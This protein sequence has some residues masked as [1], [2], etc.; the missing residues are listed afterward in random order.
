[1]RD[2]LRKY[3]KD[4]ISNSPRRAAAVLAVGIAMA[5]AAIFVRQRT[6]AAERANPP[7]GQFIEV[8]GV[9]LHYV[10]RGQGQ[11]LVLLHGNG[12]MVQDFDISGLIDL[13][14]EHYCVIAFDRPGFGYSERPRTRIW[15]PEAQADLLHKALQRLGVSNAVVL[16]HSWG[17]LV[18]L[19]LALK[20]SSDVQ[21]LVLLSGYYFP[22]LRLDAL[23]LSPPAIP[24]LGDL[25]RYT[26]SPLIGRIMWPGLLKKLF[27]PA[28]VPPRFARFPVWMALRPSQLRASAAESAL[29]VP[30]AIAFRGRYQELTMPVIIMAGSGD[31]IASAKR[32]SSRLSEQIAQSELHILP[33]VGH[34]IHHLSPSEVMMAIGFPNS[35][36]GSDLAMCL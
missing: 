25:M 24:I 23:L 29:M 7:M 32:Q 4:N 36:L 18:A 35:Y 30:S 15:S 5:G 10:E 17:T 3:V 19:A 8:D 1:M 14:S 21:R 31:R 33:G 6:R 12:T 26:V 16:G 27:G 2:A 13:A 11:P 28:R 34:M 20:Y 9:R 22:T